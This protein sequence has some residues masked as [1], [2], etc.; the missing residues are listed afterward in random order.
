MTS[1]SWEKVGLFFGS[2]CQ[3]FVNISP[4]K[5]GEYF[6]FG[7]R[8][9]FWIWDASKKPFCIPG[10]IKSIF[11][12]LEMHFIFRGMNWFVSHLDKVLCLEKRFPTRRSRKTRHPID[13]KKCYPLRI[14]WPST[15]VAIIPVIL[16]IRQ[17][18]MFSFKLILMDL[19][20]SSFFLY[21]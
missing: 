6:G 5:L 4:I 2:F 16:S 18:V 3:Q 1:A 10:K 13:L 19:I 8:Y 14:R 20:T 17:L 21:S 11:L 15:W 12:G 9:P 7:I